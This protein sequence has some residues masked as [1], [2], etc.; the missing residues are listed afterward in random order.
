M[1]SQKD[2]DK[3]PA[4]PRSWS[5]VVMPRDWPLPAQYILALSVI[6]LS[7]TTKSW[8]GTY[9]EVS[10]P[11][12][13]TLGSLLLLVLLVRPGPFLVAALTGWLGTMYFFVPPV[14][15]IDELYEPEAMVGWFIAL[16]LF[17]TALITFVLRRISDSQKVEL[18]EAKERYFSLFRSIDD[19]FC[20]IEV[21]FD[22]YNRPCDYR[23][24]E[25]NPA[26]ER[27][28][29][30]YD[31]VGKRMKQLAPGHE[32]HWFNLY[33]KVALTGV[34][35]KLV[36]RA[37]ALGRWFEVFAFRIGDP[38][39][40][41]VAVIFSDI[42]SKIEYEEALEA[43]DERHRLVRLATNDVI[44][45]WDLKNNLVEWNE[46][47]KNV[48]GYKPEDVS[49]DIAWWYEQI[50][51]EDREAIAK[52]IRRAVSS[53]ANYWRGQY[54]FRR[55]DGSYA[56]VLDRG[57][58]SRDD[59]GLAVRMIGAMLDESERLEAQ[60]A[61]EKSEATLR[62]VLDALPVG[63]TI[64]DI[65]GRPVSYNKAHL[66][67]WGAVPDTA[68]DEYDR[69]LGYWPDTGKK[70]EGN[71]W[72]MARALTKG[73]VVVNELVECERFDDGQRR[74]FLNNAAPVRDAEGNIVAGVV[75]ELDVTERLAA[76]RALQESEAMLSALVENL[77]LGVG[78]ADCSGNLLSLNPFAVKLAG[79]PS[80]AEF[81]LDPD[82]YKDDYQLF[83]MSGARL[84]AH[85]YPLARALR[86]DSVS[87]W[88]LKLISLD[89]MEHIIA[90]TA[91]PVELYP[92][93]EPLI[94]LVIQEITERKRAEVS[95]RESEER[96]RRMADDAPVV[97]WVT[98]EEGSCTFI[99]SP[100]EKLTGQSLESAQGTG[101][102]D[103]VHPDDRERSSENFKKA[104]SER[105]GFRFD[106]RL[107]RRNGS[108]QWAV[109][110]GKPRF[111]ED[112]SYLGYIGSVVDIS[113]RKELEEALKEAD[114]KKDEFLAVLAHEL[115]NPLAAIRMAMNAMKRTN[116]EKA[117]FTKMTDIIERQS[118]Q[119]S[120]L[121]DDLLDVSRITRGQ[122]VL[123]KKPVDLGSSVA[124]A[125]EG[126]KD[127]CKGKGLKLTVNL[128][129]KPLIVNVDPLRFSQV[130]GNLLTNSCKFTEEGEVRLDVRREGNTALVYVRDT[131]I[132]ISPEQLPKIFD[133]FTQVKE[134]GRSAGV[135]LGIGLS[136]AK[137]IIELHQGRIR[138]S[139]KGAGRG[140]EFVVELP[141]YDSVEQ[142]SS[143]EKVNEGLESTSAKI[144]SR[145]VLVVDDNTD[146]LE[147]V[148][149]VL[150][151]NGHRVQ[152]A[153]DGSSALEMAEKSKPEVI[154][155]DIG[156]PGMDG[157]EVAKRLRKTT[158]GARV[159]LVALT[160]WGQEKD[161][162]K[163]KLAGFDAHLTKP[164]EPDVLERVMGGSQSTNGSS[165]SARP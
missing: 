130:I 17:I 79:L 78:L 76:E 68:I 6:A 16:V 135:G 153:S 112:G 46:E 157:Y 37:G 150:E 114:R 161:K 145:H 52:S 86:G 9:F 59:S 90:H 138:A 43:S 64:S 7:L 34:P 28:T 164:V 70:I 155:L 54:R 165:E 2:K 105:K 140:S 111:A 85:E 44:W 51:P 66:E 83:D 33:G 61:L 30:L 3:S 136:L 65:R 29:G 73:E 77:P 120:S 74:F 75:A 162:E 160:G 146:A 100:W 131:G 92:G 11:F 142:I 18:M 5:G 60:A 133:M 14:G 15:R 128:P 99:S 116:G 84:S 80:N 137:S 115:R 149:I 62:A 45:D 32:E 88:E 69:W 148:A 24:I 96:F 132:G 36:E 158:W 26:F 151:M 102:L 8:F 129:Q 98:D 71:E 39:A 124:H 22:D 23:F 156:M 123:R 47:L 38:E 159:R 106:Y 91:V 13:L 117:K 109:N 56:T 121:I 55:I 126:V 42:S 89:G 143:V 104:R 41:R 141:I 49:N 21:L 58:I 97:V 25:C 93:K 10:I 125:I 63:V 108:Y 94:L 118:G 53:D 12:A 27:H 110:S 103:V 1:S 163:A 48:F 134:D 20:I 107:Q 122:V 87:E 31:A 35:E 119:L 72:A 152:L 144:H 4:T 57:F 95:L 82:G 81:P 50:H 127:T 67:L 154:L 113:D 147:A 19:G 101:W 139:S 40:H